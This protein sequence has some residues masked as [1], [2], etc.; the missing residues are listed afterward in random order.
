[1]NEKFLCDYYRMTG[2]KWNGVRGRLLMLLRYDIRYLYLIRRKKTKVR[3]LFAIRASRKYGL[4]ILSDNIGPGLY[5]GHAHNINVNPEAVIGKNCNLNKGCTLGKENRG[6]REGAPIL[7]DNVWIGTNS[8]VVG[9]VRIG[10]DVLIAPNAYVN[11][12]VPD[13]SIVLGNPGKIIRKE[14]ATEGYI[15]MR[16]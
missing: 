15:T 2:E 1:M 4:E 16:I 13:H 10:N 6:K 12:D 5:I 3:T 8:V 11:F 7:G 14:N 9:R